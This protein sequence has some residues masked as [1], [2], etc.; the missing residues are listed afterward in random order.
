MPT[1]RSGRER[2]ASFM[3]LGMLPCASGSRFG[4]RPV[5]LVTEPSI[6][7]SSGTSSD[8]SS[9]TPAIAAIRSFPATNSSIS[10]LCFDPPSGCCCRLCTSGCSDE[11][12]ELPSRKSDFAMVSVAVFEPLSCWYSD[13]SDHA[14]VK[15]PS[16]STRK[17]GMTKAAV[18]GQP[19]CV[20]RGAAWLPF[21]ALAIYRRYSD[22]AIFYSCVVRAFVDA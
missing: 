5:F 13:T 7:G 14:S 8:C 2:S 1:H 10:P 15:C 20:P 4:I 18:T 9:L 17:R 16:L 21:T 12:R 19:S 22:S 3:Y 6:C 11:S